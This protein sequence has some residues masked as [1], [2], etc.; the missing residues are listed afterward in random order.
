MTDGELNCIQGEIGNA[1][2]SVRNAWSL[3]TQSS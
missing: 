2:K 1:L 3:S